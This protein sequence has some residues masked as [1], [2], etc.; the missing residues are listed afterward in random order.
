MNDTTPAH[1]WKVGQV[2]L[3]GPHWGC[4]M[5]RKR[6]EPSKIYVKLVTIF[7]SLPGWVTV[8]HAPAG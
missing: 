6:P 7:F 4:N 1:D 8:H 5:T 2:I 3:G